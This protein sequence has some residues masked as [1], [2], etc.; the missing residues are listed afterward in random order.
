MYEQL[1]SDDLMDIRFVNVKDDLPQFERLVE[2]VRQIRDPLHF[3]CGTFEI[4]A[5]Y[6]PDGYE[7]EDCLRSI[8]GVTL[9]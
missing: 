1:N 4:I 5:I 3:K 8:A 6:P 2:Y 9:P 7:I